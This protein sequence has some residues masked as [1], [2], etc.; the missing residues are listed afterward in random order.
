ML[1]VGPPMAHLSPEQL[2]THVKSSSR[3]LG[4]R[5]RLAALALLLLASAASLTACIPVKP[6][7]LVFGDSLTHESVDYIKFLTGNEYD[8]RVTAK[9]GTALCDYGDSIVN[10]ARNLRPK[11][12]VLAFSGNALTPCM[13]GYN[14]HSQIAQKYESDANWVAGNLSGIGVPI[15]FVTPPPGLRRASGV[16]A[17]ST[18]DGLS[19]ALAVTGVD[20]GLG[21]AAAPSTELSVMRS[22]GE[23]PSGLYSSKSE[24][25]GIYRRVSGQWRARNAQV[26][27][28]D[29]FTP[30]ASPTGT[31][32]KVQPCA[33][34]EAANVLC[35]NGLIDVRAA[36]LGHFCP[37]TV[38]S[39]DLTPICSTYS[40][41]AFRWGGAIAD[42][43][44]FID[45]QTFGALDSV[46]SG[47]RSVSVSGWA[48]DPSNDVTATQVHVYVGSTG[49]AVI[50]SNPRADVGMVYPVAGPNHGFSATFNAPPGSHNVCVYAINVSG[51]GSNVGLGCRVVQVGGGAPFGI[52]DSATLENGSIRVTGWAID[53]DTASSL[54]I[55]IYLQGQ[56]YPLLAD[57]NRPDIARALPAYGPAHGFNGLVP[58]PEGT[59]RICAYAIDLAG[60]D[61]NSLLGCRT[62]TVPPGNP[63]GFIDG[64]SIA[65]GIVSLNGWAIDPDTASPVVMHVYVNGVGHQIIAN[66]DRP[67]LGNPWGLGSLHGWTFAAPRVGS[68]LQRVCV[69]TLNIAGTG[70]HQLLGCRELP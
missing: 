8:V 10:D 41:G 58:A 18:T 14:T 66:E 69:Y 67:D 43:V 68:G 22:V 52:V 46:S 11:L 12:V 53:P 20:T 49:Y 28:I 2:S 32:T 61:V 60:G 65:N 59:N 25:D 64:A 54:P 38:T 27:I 39:G 44:R 36:D 13:S 29:G 16:N 55:H 15:A 6:I 35:R 3:P 24:L 50:A 26:G 30:F 33:P 21:I 70:S 63:I 42:Y 34:W 5:L 17:T 62:V 19:D 9:G 23:I 40:P 37:G 4:R 1:R 48:I 57:K 7:V 31:W 47:I 56:V 45:Q 51:T